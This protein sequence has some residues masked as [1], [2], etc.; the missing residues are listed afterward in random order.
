MT[1]YFINLAYLSILIGPSKVKCM[2]QPFLLAGPGRQLVDRPPLF[3]G[4][5]QPRRFP[6]VWPR[7]PSTALGGRGGHFQSSDC[8]PC[9]LVCAEKNH[10]HHTVPLNLKD[11]FQSSE[12]RPCLL[13]C[14]ENNSRYC[15][16]NLKGHF[17]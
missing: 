15:F 5:S 3:G 11:T 7:Q 4:H 10:C 12:G 8:R 1:K 14:A 2:C 6:A 17:L 9:Q 13:A 16:F